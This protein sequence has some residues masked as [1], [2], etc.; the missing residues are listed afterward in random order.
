[1]A[2]AASLALACD[3]VLGSTELIDH[4]VPLGAFDNVF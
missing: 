3:D 4:E 2:D 1:L